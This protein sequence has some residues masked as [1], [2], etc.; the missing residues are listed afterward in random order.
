MPACIM[1]M[2]AL[3]A[4]LQDLGQAQQLE[5]WHEDIPE[6]RAAVLQAQRAAAASTDKLLAAKMLRLVS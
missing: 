2:L 5:P 3:Q 4:A 1:M 6:L